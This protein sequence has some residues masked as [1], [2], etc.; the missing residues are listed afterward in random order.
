MESRGR[1]SNR[2]S[3][4]KLYLTK[5]VPMSQWRKRQLD[6]SVY[7]FFPIS[8]PKS[9]IENSFSPTRPVKRGDE[10]FFSTHLAC[11]KQE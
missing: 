1:F 9:T 8:R 5:C 2:P 10:Y 3:M 6:N 4:T 11:R 7:L